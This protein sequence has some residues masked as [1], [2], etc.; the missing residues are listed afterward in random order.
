MIDTVLELLPIAGYEKQAD[1]D[2]D[3]LG[4]V[5]PVYMQSL[6]KLVRSFLK[7]IRVKGD[8]FI[9]SVAT[10]NGEPGHSLFT[11]NRLLKHKGKSL[12]LGF[13]VEMPGNSLIG[14]D[15][16]NPPEIQKERLAKV[17]GKLSLI[18]QAITEKN[19]NIIEGDNS[20][21]VY[22][23]GFIIKSFLKIYKPARRFWVRNICTHCGTCLRV[24]P[25]QNITMD[26][27]LGPTWGDKCQ[28]C[29]ACFHWCPHQAVELGKDTLGKRRY[30]HPEVNVDELII[31]QDK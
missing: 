21:G 27:K 26:P 22:L 4:I 17:N 14:T 5:F 25:V 23:K 24:C 30:H 2:G 1:F 3:V 18:A 28:Y 12:K 6:P 19:Q 29:L 8:P 7:K 11:V 15:F 20:A 9:F 31:L 10:N 16:T 13:A